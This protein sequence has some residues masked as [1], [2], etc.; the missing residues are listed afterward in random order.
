MARERIKLVHKFIVHACRDNL[1]ADAG[2]PVTVIA[3]GIEMLFR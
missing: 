3:M 2:D 1:V